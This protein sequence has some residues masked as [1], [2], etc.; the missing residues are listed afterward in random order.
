MIRDVAQRKKFTIHLELLRH[1][2]VCA[3]SALF[4]GQRGHIDE[5]RNLRAISGNPF[6]GWLNVCIPGYDEHI[7]TSAF[8]RVTHDFHGQVDIGLFF[9][10]YNIFFSANRPAGYLPRLE[11]SHDQLDLG[12]GLKDGKILLLTLFGIR[13]VVNPRGKQLNGN[14]ILIRP[15][16]GKKL[17]NIEPFL[18]RAM[19]NNGM[20]PIVAVNIDDSFFLHI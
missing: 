15:Q 2:I 7:F 4:C 10:L 14:Y 3:A 6:H 8:N 13:I 9:L 11:N 5:N 19:L 17:L 12:Q 18:L 20:I 16:G 1:I